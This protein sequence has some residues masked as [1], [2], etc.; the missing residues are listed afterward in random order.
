MLAEIVVCRCIVLWEVHNAH[1]KVVNVP[2]VTKIVSMKEKK[3]K[4]QDRKEEVL[5]DLVSLE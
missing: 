2:T 1:V 5:P 4:K 3:K